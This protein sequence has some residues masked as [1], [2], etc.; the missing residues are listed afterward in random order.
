MTR[1]RAAWTLGLAC[2]LQLA[3][4]SASAQSAP[5]GT[6]EQCYL[7]VATSERSSEGVQI[8]RELCDLAFGL[9]VRPIAFFDPKSKACKE[10]WFDRRGRYED[11]DRYCSF[12]AA[13][14]GQWK[15]ACQWKGDGATTFVRLQEDGR[16]FQRVGELA[17]RDVGEAFASLASCIESTLSPPAP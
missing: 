5:P 1:T 15:L 3:G 4:A 14:A 7:T 12:E 9:S 10:W 17:G 2:A 8:A 13:G 6:V 11:A 16:R